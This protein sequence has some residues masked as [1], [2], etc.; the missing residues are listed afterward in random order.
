MAAT[1]LARSS[2]AH[3]RRVLAR[4]AP[5]VDPDGNPPLAERRT[6]QRLCPLRSVTCGL[7]LRSLAAE[8]KLSHLIS[9]R[10][11]LFGENKGGTPSS[12]TI[13]SVPLVQRWHQSIR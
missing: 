8:R 2:L 7:F 5:L 4:V 11:A 9:G 6:L 3:R 13:S 1:K 10:C 12:R